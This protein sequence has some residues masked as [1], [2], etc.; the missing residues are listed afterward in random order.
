MD[1]GLA[2]AWDNHVYAGDIYGN[3]AQEIRFRTQNLP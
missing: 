1:W 2:E 3:Q